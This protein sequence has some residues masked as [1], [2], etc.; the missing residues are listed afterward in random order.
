MSCPSM[1]DLALVGV[2]EAGEQLDDG[3]LARAVLAHQ[4]HRLVG[5]DRE[6]DVAQGRLVLPG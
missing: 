2:V 6:A 5:R 3:G 1:Q 4:G